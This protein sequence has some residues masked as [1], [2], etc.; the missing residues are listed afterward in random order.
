MP[1]PSFFNLLIEAAVIGCL[2]IIFTTLASFIFRPTNHLVTLF[3]AG[4]SLHF[5]F[6]FMGWNLLYCQ[7]YIA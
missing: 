6:E 5:F 1:K 7:K 2:T 3:I 4:A